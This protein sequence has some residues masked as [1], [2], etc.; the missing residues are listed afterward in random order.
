LAASLLITLTGATK[1]VFSLF[2]LSQVN[3]SLDE[4]WLLLLELG[5]CR[6]PLHL[7]LNFLLLVPLRSLIE[8]PQ[9]VSGQRISVSV[10]HL[11]LEA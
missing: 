8:C 9:V 2:G 3:Y 4:K 11:Q 6:S 7:E 1:E 10:F 5:R